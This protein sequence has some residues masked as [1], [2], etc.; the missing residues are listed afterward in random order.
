MKRIYVREGGGQSAAADGDGQAA[1]NVDVDFSEM[2]TGKGVIVD[3]GTTDTYLH[4]SIAGPFEAVWRKV[5]GSKYSNAPVK[6]TEEEL[7]KLPTVLIQLEGAGNDV[8]LQVRL[9]GGG[10]AVML[11]HIVDRSRPSNVPSFDIKFQGDGI[12]VGLAGRIDPANPAD[13]ILAVP[14]TNYMEYSP[15][16]DT[17]TPRIY[18]TE[19]AGGVIGANAMQG[20][21]VIFDWE[22]GRVGFAESTCEYLDEDPGPGD[23]D[24]GQTSAD[25]R[26]GTPSLSVSCSDSADLSRCDVGGSAAAST[27]PLSGL[28]F[29]TRVVKSPGTPQGASCEDVSLAENAANGGGK[30]EVNCDGRGVCREVRPCSISCANAMAHGSGGGTGSA[31]AGLSPV[32]SCGAVTWSACD[33]TCTQTRVNS[34][35]MN[36]GKC[37]EER[38][39]E[40]TRACHV[41]ACGRSDPCRV[42][43]VVHAILRIRGAVAGSWDR[44]AEEVFATAF[45]GAV[46]RKKRGASKFFGDGDV[47]VLN[48]S[49]WR[50]GD[51]SAISPTP[52]EED[53]ELGMQLVVEVSLFNHKAEIPPIIAAPA[54]EGGPP[55]ATCHE[56]DVQPLAA[57]A[58]NIHRRLKEKNFVSSVVA[59]MKRSDDIGERRQSPFY[60]TFEDPKLARQSFTV[61]S[62]TIKTDIGGDEDGL[63]GLD[64]SLREVQ[65]DLLFMTLM[66]IATGY[67][68]WNLRSWLLRRAR[69][70]Q[71][72]A[73]R[74]TKLGPTRNTP[75]RDDD[76]SVMAIA[77]AYGNGTVGGDDESTAD[78]SMATLLRRGAGRP[79]DATSQGSIGSISAYL[80]KTGSR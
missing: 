18:F 3:S 76:D 6:M 16:K 21:N 68:G 34:V 70:V 20:H 19:T 66:I 2:N 43:F 35:L 17:Y 77:D 69:L 53:E 74:Y 1:R 60:Y 58:L 26:L 5:T 40:I 49:P 61:T 27:E 65:L 9:G 31:G 54:G 57:A 79:S 80:A 38:S 37:H 29:W 25:C 59:L 55:L 50:A 42:P 24:G 67:L 23:G 73:G 8:N 62:W 28:E 48:A 11:F 51:D 39:E 44:H 7:L 72:A 64:M 78:G 63:A 10:K 41:Q 75:A 71:K 36:D 46:N 14:A 47:L 15:S 52:G 45:A 4:R 30:M 32:G 56:R 33:Y 12:A 13:A 22:R